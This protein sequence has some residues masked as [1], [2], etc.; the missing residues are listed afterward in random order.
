MPSDHFDC[1]I[2]SLSPLTRLQVHPT[3]VNHLLALQ[4]SFGFPDRQLDDLALLRGESDA[5]EAQDAAMDTAEEWMEHHGDQFLD[6]K[7][8]RAEVKSRKR[9][10][11]CVPECSTFACSLDLLVSSFRLLFKCAPCFAVLLTYVF[12]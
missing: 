8:R 3:V 1:A 2:L 5:Q 9:E 7:K 11:A 12:F 6:V 4:P 10:S